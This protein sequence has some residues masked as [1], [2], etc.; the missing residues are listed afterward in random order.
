MTSLP[1][2][3][4]IPITASPAL[5]SRT[6]HHPTRPLAR[7]PDLHPE[8]PPRLLPTTHHVDARQHD[9]EQDQD[10]PGFNRLWNNQYAV[11]TELDM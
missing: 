10:Q 3:P 2:C 8:R 5:S 7:T 4:P 1:P 11:L 9:P 6:P